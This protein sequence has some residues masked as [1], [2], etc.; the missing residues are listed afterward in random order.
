MYMVMVSRVA[1]SMIPFCTEGNLNFA[2]HIG[3]KMYCGK[4]ILDVYRFSCGGLVLIFFVQK[5]DQQ[6]LS[7]P[8]FNNLF[9]S[10]RSLF[11]PLLK[12]WVFWVWSVLSAAC[13]A[14]V[15][16]PENDELLLPWSQKQFL[17]FYRSL[18]VSVFFF[19]KILSHIDG[20]SC[21]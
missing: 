7:L 10:R 11:A 13:D 21:P 15:F 14:L 4:A 18:L 20:S 1:W 5:S 8:I 12:A 16:F 6:L 3:I 9:H 17:R 19:F 2:L